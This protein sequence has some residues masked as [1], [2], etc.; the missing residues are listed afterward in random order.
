MFALYRY[1]KRLFD[2]TLFRVAVVLMFG[3]VVMPLAVQA[4]VVGQANGGIMMMVMRY[5]GVSQQSAC[6]QQQ[7]YKRCCFFHYTLIQCRFTKIM[8]YFY[9]DTRASANK[10]KKL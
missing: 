1:G 2:E 7:E 6:C 9:F 5:S 8:K 3:I 4:V 10:F